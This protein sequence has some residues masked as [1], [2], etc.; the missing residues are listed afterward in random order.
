MDTQTAAIK[1]LMRRHGWSW[2]RKR[3]DCG[4]CLRLGALQLLTASAGAYEDKAALAEFILSEEFSI[5]DSRD[6]SEEAQGG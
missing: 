3:D 4:G 6:S 1:A 2:H 5:A